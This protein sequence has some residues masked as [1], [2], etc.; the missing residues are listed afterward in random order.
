MARKAKPISTAVAA[1]SNT[2]KIESSKSGIVTIPGIKTENLRT[3]IIGTSPLICHKFSEKLRKMILDKHM[4]EASAGREKKDPFSN[5][6]AARYR[7][8]DGSDGVPAGGVKAAI[9]DGFGKDAGVFISKAKGGIRVKADDVSTNLVRLYHRSNP[10]KSDIMFFDRM[11]PKEYA[12]APRLREDVVRNESGVVDIRHRPVYWPWAMM[13]EVEYLPE[14]ASFRQVLQ[15][16]ARSGF[17]VGLC[18]WRPSSKQ[19]KSGSY[20]TWRLATTP[21]IAAYEDGTLF[22]DAEMKEAAE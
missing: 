9:V 1:P 19:S 21:E 17:T 20:G 10:D 22:D 16:I 2:D 7:L 12:I 3:L 13:I 6:D 18:E 15:A 8:S 11:T 5:F 14:I 4:G